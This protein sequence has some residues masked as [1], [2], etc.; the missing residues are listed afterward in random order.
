MKFSWLQDRKSFIKEDTEGKIKNFY[1]SKE[2]IKMEKI[3]HKLGNETH[4]LS[5]NRFISRTYKEFLA[6]NYEKTLN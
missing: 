1:A 2:P 4:S 5:D 3:N 6:I